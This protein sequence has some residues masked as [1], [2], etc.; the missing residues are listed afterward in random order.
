[1]PTR[2]DP[3]LTDDENPELTPEQIRSMRPASEVLPGRALR[4]ADQCWS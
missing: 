1:M 3:Y 2:P 4:C